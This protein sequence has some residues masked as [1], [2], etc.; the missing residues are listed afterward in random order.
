M[1][2]FTH[3]ISI[4]NLNPHNASLSNDYMDNLWTTGIQLLPEIGNQV[5]GLKVLDAFKSASFIKSKS[6]RFGWRERKF[7][8]GLA[9]KLTWD[10]WMF[11]V[12][13]AI[14]DSIFDTYH[15]YVHCVIDDATKSLTIYRRMKDRAIRELRLDTL[16][17]IRK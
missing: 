7:S 17:T 1:Q 12:A 8:Q 6:D 2:L 9:I 15:E 10:D 4:R 14:A 11:S 13:R 5:L 16:H 3:N